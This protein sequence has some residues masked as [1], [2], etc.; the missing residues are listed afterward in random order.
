MEKNKKLCLNILYNFEIKDFYL[1]FSQYM[2]I[3]TEILKL[4]ILRSEA[5]RIAREHRYFA[6]I[7]QTEI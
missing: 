3:L 1:C 5:F 2:T 7:I 6:N 4:S